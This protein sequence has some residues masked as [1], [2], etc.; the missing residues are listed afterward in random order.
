M[1]GQAAGFILTKEAL[2]E[3][4]RNVGFTLF[5]LVAWVYAQSKVQWERG[6]NRC[7]LE[8]LGSVWV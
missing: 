8:T 7:T 3:L 4:G 6:G 5:A 1:S 2:Q